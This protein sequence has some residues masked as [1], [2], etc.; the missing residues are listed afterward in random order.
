M[1]VYRVSGSMQA[2]ESRCPPSQPSPAQPLAAVLPGARGLAPLT[3]FHIHK[4]GPAKCL[5]PRVVVRLT[6]VT[7]LKHEAPGSRLPRLTPHGALN[8]HNSPPVIPTAFPCT[9]LSNPA[10]RSW[11][12]RLCTCSLAR[13]ALPPALACDSPHRSLAPSLWKTV[14]DLSGPSFS[15]PLLLFLSPSQTPSILVC[16]S[17]STLTPLSPRP[18]S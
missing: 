2:E 6:Q 17:H 7:A 3:G 12:L 13:S 5:P 1:R 11:L 9:L 15:L 4:R 18:P 16:L 14:L 10:P 8:T